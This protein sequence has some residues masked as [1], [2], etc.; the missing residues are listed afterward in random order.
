MMAVLPIVPSTSGPMRDLLDAF[1]A[2]CEA[3][4]QLTRAVAAYDQ[5]LAKF[6]NQKE[7]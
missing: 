4:D 1:T 5:A 2:V 7:A 6:D 3:K